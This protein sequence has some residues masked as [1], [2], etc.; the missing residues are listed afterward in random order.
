MGEHQTKW[1]AQWSDRATQSP[2]ILR[3]T[4]HAQHAWT[5]SVGSMPC[6]RAESW[7]FARRRNGWPPN[8]DMVTLPAFGQRVQQRGVDA[9]RDALRRAFADRLAAALAQLLHVVAAFGLVGPAPDVLL[10]DLL[11]WIASTTV[12]DRFHDIHV[13]RNARQVKAHWSGS[14]TTGM[15]MRTHRPRAAGRQGDAVRTDRRSRC[16]RAPITIDTAR[17]T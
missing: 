11:A 5:S 12:L 10:S 2:E 6:R 7:A 16:R 15:R 1:L 8:G 3:Q 4:R 9:H 14:R 17:S 13:L